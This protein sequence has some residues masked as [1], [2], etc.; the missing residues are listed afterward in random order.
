V[1]RFITG[2]PWVIGPASVVAIAPPPAEAELGDVAFEGASHRVAVE[3]AGQV[4]VEVAAEEVAPDAELA[5]F[6][7]EPGEGAGVRGDV[8]A[9][10]KEGRTR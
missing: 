9:E 2:D 1:G 5:R 4:Q 7:V 6:G 10:L 8:E 3:G